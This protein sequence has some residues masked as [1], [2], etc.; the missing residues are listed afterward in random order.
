M[1]SPSEFVRRRAGV[2][3]V[4]AL[5]LAVGV[6]SHA[7][8]QALLGRLNQPLQRVT[9]ANRSWKPLFEAIAAMTPPPKPVGPDFNQTTIWTGMPDWTA[10]AAWAEANAKVAD[11][12]KEVQDKIVL[13][14]PYGADAVPANFKQ[15]GLYAAVSVTDDARI[16]TFPYLDGIRTLGAWATAEMYRLCEAGEFDAAF[17]IGVSHLKVLRQI[18]DRSMLAEKSLGMLWMCEAC[19]IQRDL[20][21]KYLDKIPATT[22][23][24]LANDEY[25]FLRPT[26]NE[27][28]KRLEMPEG[29]RVVAEAMLELGFDS[30]GQ[31]D[32]DRFEEVFAEIQASSKPLT[33]FGAAKR[34]KAIAAV[35]GSLDASKT[36]LENIYDDWWR[37][38]RMRQYDPLQELPT[39][40]SRTNEIRYAAVVVSILDI[41][42]LFA[43]RNRLV[44]EVNGTVLAA[45]LC[46]YKRTFNVW[47]D[48]PA[49]YYA[50]FAPKRFDFD[51]YDR[52]Y[53]SFLFRFLGS[54]RKP[55]DTPEGRVWVTGCV[56]YARGADHEDGGFTEGDPT[57]AA[58]DLILF[59]PLRALARE[60]GLL[61]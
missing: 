60:E 12:L 58:G 43:L 47:P 55:I 25:P 2:H 3:A 9:E 10:V 24:R 54:D 27:R 37:R 18:A 36:K 49:K 13:G 33:R 34:W 20:F 31:P 7:D 44:A 17:A 4:A 52:E 21:W 22:F 51:P 28:M 1:V 61:N 23:Q 19:S 40:L 56:L 14:L 5:A 42:S 30:N 53:G 35:H 38:W 29:D 39:E 15:A 26:D 41:Q 32:I 59:P 48:L 46:G 45:G 8:D 6:I 57:G 11:A 16:T 50:V